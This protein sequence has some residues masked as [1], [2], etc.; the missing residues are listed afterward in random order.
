[1][2]L[3]DSVLR[4]LAIV[5]LLVFGVSLAVPALAA[6]IEAPLSRLARFGPKDMGD[7]FVSGL[8]VGGAL[9]FVYTPCA[10]PILA[11]VISVGATTGTTLRTLLVALAYAIGSALVL[12]VLMAGGRRLLPRTVTVQRALGA[13]LV[14][15]AFAMIAR[16]DVRAEKAI[17][18]HAPNANLAAGLEDSSAVVGRLDRIRPKARFEQ[19]AVRP[20][21]KLPVLGTAPDF[22]GTQRWFNSKPLSLAALRGRVVLIDFWT[23]TC[24]NCIRTLPYLKAWDARYRRAGLTIVGV[25]SPEFSFE[26]DAGNVQRAIRSFGIRYPVVQDNNLATWSAWGNQYWP[27]E[28]LIDARGK[29]RH[30]HFGEGDYDKSEAAIRSLLAERDGHVG[31]MAKPRDP[32]TI[33]AETTPETYLGSARAER[34]LPDTPRDGT[35]TYATPASLPLSHFALGGTW[36]VTPEDATAVRGASLTAHVQARHVYLVLGGTG[37]VGVEVDGRHTRTVH[38]TKQELYTLADFPRAGKHVLRLTFAPGVSGFA[39]TFG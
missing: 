31:E 35:N 19:H 13:V 30:V 12:L 20:R 23:Y 26:K 10:G 9:G 33:S 28:Y 25:H 32:F 37:D 11:A 5:V 16:L 17:A 8:A 36:R 15:T 6:R 18:E 3:G 27:A 22:T 29:V 38:V 24:I 1:V 39:F 34:W 7:G 14:L 21:S 4:D 2:G